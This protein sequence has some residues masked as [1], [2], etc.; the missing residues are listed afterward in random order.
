MYSIAV[1]N[2]QKSAGKTA[3]TINLGHALSLAGYPVT[4][5]DLDSAGDLSSGLG[6]F[7]PPTQG[8]DQVLQGTAT[9]DS[10]TISTRDTLHLIPAGAGLAEFEREQ[11]S[12]SESGLRL[13]QA[14]TGE[15]PDQSVMIFDCPS[16]S[17][18]LTANLLLGVNMVL[19]PV[20]GDDEGAAALPRLLE[21]IRQFRS[22]RERPLDYAV[23][24]NRIP[25][26]RRLTGPAA[27]KFCSL[28]PDHF[29]RSV[30]CQSDLI[31]RARSAGRTVFEYRPNSRSAEDFRLLAQELVKR[32]GQTDG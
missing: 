8:I 12:E 6:L 27:S 14:I 19:M 25:Q 18:A 13:R 1:F 3:T 28:A 9:L 21:T 7:R 31:D 26:R 16:R 2:D 24:M 20:P 32:M 11:P 30:I 5:V 4:L 17:G 15:T 10:V 23:L 22:A 29:L